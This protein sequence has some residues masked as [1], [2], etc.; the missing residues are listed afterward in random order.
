MYKH[1]EHTFIPLG[2]PDRG[3]M[4]KRQEYSFTVN[5]D[6]TVTT[7]TTSD[8]DRHN[9]V[10]IDAGTTAAIV[11]THPGPGNV[12]STVQPS[13]DDIALAQST[14][15]PDYVL[16]INEL[17]VANTNGSIAKLA[18]VSMKHGDLVFKWK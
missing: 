17:W 2:M 14:G 9:E 8:Q 16:S 5:K 11:H 13:H 18:D 4:T 7:V 15:I 10:T 12:E 6:G 3:E 1:A